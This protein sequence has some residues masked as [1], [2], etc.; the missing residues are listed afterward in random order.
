V[1]VRFTYVAVVHLFFFF[2][3]KTAY[4]IG[5]GINL[6]ALAALLG[7]R[8]LVPLRGLRW[9][10]LGKAA[11]VSIVA[12]VISFEVAKAAPVSGVGHGS[13]I[14]DLAQLALVSVTWAAATALGLWL[15]KSELPR[16]LRRP[17]AAAYP[18]VA[19][20]E[21]REIMGAGREP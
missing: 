13:R 5:I 14:A 18:A 8:E 2:K 15:L 10:E 17:R 20:A 7:Y 9:K 19:Q 16:D 1:C 12:G 6:L 21:S 4:E 3:Q 11:L